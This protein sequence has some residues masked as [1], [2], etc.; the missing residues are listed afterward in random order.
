MSTTTAT[1]VQAVA[2]VAT[3][4]GTTAL[5][6][7]RSGIAARA[8]EDGTPVTDADLDAEGAARRWIESHFPGDAIVGE[9]YGGTPSETGR[10]WYIDPIDGTKTFMRGV[11]LWGSMA[12]VVENGVVLAGAVRYPALEEIV[13]A[14]RGL[15]T[16]A[17]GVRCKVSDVARIEDALLLT[18]NARS[19]DDA[20]PRERWRALAD[21]AALVRTWGDCYGYLLVASGR[22][23][24]MYDPKLESWDAGAPEVIVE[25][26]GG[27]FTDVRGEPGIFG[28]SGL[29]TNAALSDLVREA[30]GARTTHEAQR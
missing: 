26:A 13:A 4:M 22:A 6:R 9:E 27:R 12:A 25:E 7:Y 2:D 17:N 16:F 5:R 19:G 23:E 1:L 28:G 24:V 14:G 29:A 21:R 20:I 10:S 11:P 15:G 18:T 3:R 30:L 8:K